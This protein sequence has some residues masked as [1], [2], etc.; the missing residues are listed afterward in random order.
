MAAL[1]AYVLISDFPDKVL[2]RK[3]PFLT[4]SDVELVKG[5]I[6]RDRDDAKADPLSMGKVLKHLS[7]WKLWA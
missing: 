1:C 3:N 6:D 4:A 7:D 2:Q 5:R